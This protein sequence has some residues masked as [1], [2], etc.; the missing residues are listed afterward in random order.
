VQVVAAVVST[1]ER[2]QVRLV[3]VELAVVVMLH[4]RVQQ[5]QQER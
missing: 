5:V 3:R 2:M 1:N 4:L